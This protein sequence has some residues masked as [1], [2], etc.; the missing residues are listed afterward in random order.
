MNVDFCVVLVLKTKFPSSKQQI[1]KPA[2]PIVIFD[3][4]TSKL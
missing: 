1:W 4:K 3:Q 2:A